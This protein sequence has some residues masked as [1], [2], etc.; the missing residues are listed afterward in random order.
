M[1]YQQTATPSS[2]TLC[3]KPIRAEDVEKTRTLIGL[4]KNNMH[5]T[6]PFKCFKSRVRFPIYLKCGISE[7]ALSTSVFVLY[8]VSK[9]INI[10]Y[11][12]LP[13]AKLITVNVTTTTLY[14]L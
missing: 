2:R 5:A 7:T 6:A 8:K 1:C 4:F 10:S 13:S 3:S 9:R 11:S 14:R 12:N